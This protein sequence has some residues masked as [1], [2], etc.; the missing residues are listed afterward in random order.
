MSNCQRERHSFRC[1]RIDSVLW[2]FSI[3]TDKDAEFDSRDEP[4]TVLEEGS[5]LPQTNVHETC[6]LH[7]K[8]NVQSVEQQISQVA[9]TRSIDWTR[10]IDPGCSRSG[11]EE[12]TRHW[13][14]IMHSHRAA[15]DRQ[16]YFIRLLR[17]AASWVK[18][19]QVESPVAFLIPLLLFLLS[20]S[21]HDVIISNVNIVRLFR[22]ALIFKHLGTSSLF[23]SCSDT[24]LLTSMPSFAASQGL[25]PWASAHVSRSMLT[26]STWQGGVC[27]SPFRFSFFFVESAYDRT[28]IASFPFRRVCRG[29]LSARQNF[30]NSKSL[31][32]QKC[33][34]R[35]M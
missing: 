28:S 3:G 10:R 11:M 15:S 24:F 19:W 23:P 12:V 1:D 6:G 21:V 35:I 27:R 16:L 30:Q 22:D 13:H 34:N 2:E 20:C 32:P 14:Y 17:G 25:G 33:V 9:G 18:E 29:R 31:A 7:R 5:L 8:G 4:G 26:F